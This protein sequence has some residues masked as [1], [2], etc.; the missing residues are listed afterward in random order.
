MYSLKFS[1]FMNGNYDE[2]IDSGTVLYVIRDMNNKVL[3]IG[4]SRAGIWNR[5]FSSVRSHIF[6]NYLGEKYAT[7]SIG[8][9]ILE[10][11]PNSNNFIIELWKIKELCKKFGVKEEYGYY[12]LEELEAEM[13]H[14]YHPALNI[15]NANYS[16]D[17]N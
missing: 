9:Y 10:N 8:K 1:D 14:E 4:I 7:S 2:K 6:Q 15:M 3:Y 11:L 12:L 16:K 5:W 17:L 13:I